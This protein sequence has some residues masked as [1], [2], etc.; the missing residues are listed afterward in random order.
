MTFISKRLSATKPQLFSA[1]CIVAAFST[2]FCMY[3]FRKPFT[4]GTFEDVMLWGIGYKTILV[5]AQVSGYTL[6]KFIGIKVISEMSA[7]WRA[8]AII[9][10]LSVAELSLLLFAVVPPPWNAACRSRS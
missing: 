8:V 4:A 6:S 5:A 3:A 9:G 7:R 2:Y 10:V 1:Y